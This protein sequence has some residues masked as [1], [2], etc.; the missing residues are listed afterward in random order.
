MLH[1]QNLDNWLSKSIHNSLFQEWKKHAFMHHSS[2]EALEKAETG[3]NE[4]HYV[5]GGGLTAAKK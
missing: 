2:G 4:K 5:E 3:W 1:I